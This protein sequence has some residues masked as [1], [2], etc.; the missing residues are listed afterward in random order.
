MIS[1]NYNF[2]AFIDFVA[3]HDYLEILRLADS[4]CS[5]AE[6]ASYSVRGAAQARSLGSTDYARAIKAFI[7]FLRS[8]IQ[9]AGASDSEFRSYRRVCEK[10][11][12]KKQFKPSVL[13]MF[14]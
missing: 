1:R 3:D 2:D 6:R 12:E 9:P 14:D 10:L 4:E 11:V 8:G 13:R 7:F 5:S